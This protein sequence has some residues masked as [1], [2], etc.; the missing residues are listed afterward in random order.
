MGVPDSVEKIR[1]IRIVKA[2]AK[3]Q[4]NLVYK[5][6]K[7]D[8]PNSENVP[9]GPRETY[10]IYTEHGLVGAAVFTGA[11]K[12]SGPLNAWMGWSKAKRDAHIN[13]V[14]NMARFLVRPCVKCRNLASRLLSLL[15]ARVPGDYMMD[16][17]LHLCVLTT[18]VDSEAHSGACYRAA[19]WDEIGKT[20]GRGWRGPKIRA[21]GETPVSPKLVFVRT[22][23]PDFRKRLGL[24]DLQ[25]CTAPAWYRKGALS[26]HDGL[27][28]G[29]QAF[30]E[31]EL[32]ASPLGKGKRNRRAATTLGMLYDMP[33][34]VISKAG[35]G[36][37]KKSKG[38]YRF[39]ETEEEQV[40]MENILAGH[41]ECT[42]RRMM[43]QEVV[44]ATID[45]TEYNY[46]TKRGTNRDM[47][48][49][50]R[51]QAHTSRGLVQYATLVH[52]AGGLP[53]GILKLTFAARNFRK[54][55]DPRPSPNRP[56]EE[57]ETN[58]W[59]EHAMHVNEVARWMPNTTVILLCDRESDFYQFLALAAKLPN[60]QVILRAKVSRE[61]VGEKN[62]LFPLLA[63]SDECARMTVRVPRR[64]E[65]PKKPGQ[66]AR[67]ERKAR[68]AELS[69]SMRRVTFNPPAR[70]RDEK[71]VTVSAVVAVEMDPPEPAYLERLHWIVLST[72]ELKRGSDAV[73]C[74]EHYMRRWTI[75]EW[76]RVIKD[77]CRV[78]DL[79]LRDIDHMKRAM[80]L[81]VLVAWFIMYRLKLGLKVD[82]LPVE[83]VFDELEAAV[84]R[85][86]VMD[87]NLDV[88]DAETAKPGS[89]ATARG[90]V[91]AV[92]RLGGH[93]G[94]KGDGDP[95]LETF[96][97]GTAVLAVMRKFSLALRRNLK[98]AIIMLVGEMS[99]SMI[100][101]TVWQAFVW[102]GL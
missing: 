95:G 64:S 20:Q 17:R 50:G 88:E 19:G 31:R 1:E 27:S 96:G 100:L 62:P 25:W 45:G 40:T 85:I 63:K 30:F 51:N 32:E 97:S 22:I 34:A 84:L 6:L 23:D 72:A 38:A 29:V 15:E 81:K 7:E 71:P 2:V 43:A 36:L 48:D 55:G 60:V 58:V 35:G 99:L 44:F 92:A 18:F 5:L 98:Q 82:N 3:E 52:T 101:E 75:E 53:L 37:R 33:P 26:L 79:A 80:T 54:P 76:H 14:I 65:Q 41:V 39:C 90:A 91:K 66:A 49:I 56:I 61:V 46:D 9:P 68:E 87:M 77:C 12:N 93:L 102:D 74:V 21:K 94:R 42:C 59:L 11:P 70:L 78:E 89:L 16:H 57:K 69:L 86:V 28:G 4:K 47:G 8:H 13:C 83:D 24:P 10:L 67:T 73:A